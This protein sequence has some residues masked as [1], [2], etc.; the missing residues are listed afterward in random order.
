[1]RADER[2]C[3]DNDRNTTEI[4][5]YAW[6][7]LSR[8]SLVTDEG[9]AD[10]ESDVAV[11]PDVGLRHG[12]L[13]LF[14]HHGSPDAEV[15]DIAHEVSAWLAAGESPGD[16]VVLYGSCYAGNFP[17]VD[18]LR[19]SFDRAG[20]RWYWPTDPDAPSKNL[21]GARND[22]VMICTIYSAKGLEFKNVILCAYLD[23]R[24]PEELEAN[25]RLIYV[26]MTRAKE[27][28]V[29][30]ASGNHPHIAD[31]ELGTGGKLS[32]SSPFLDVPRSEWLASNAV[33]VRDR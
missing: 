30:M 25:R 21:A 14:R 9:N 19:S 1:M 29:L 2:K 5:D 6:S 26:G 3:C 16:I 8:S 17:W 11:H 28:L 32:D 27:R 31:L 23:D 18:K 20:V 33:G 22:A 12:P 24:P 7:F 4:L 10:A 15:L 13:P